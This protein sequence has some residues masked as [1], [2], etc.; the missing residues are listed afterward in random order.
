MLATVQGTLKEDGTLE[1]DEQL[2]LPPG[3]VRITVQ[4]SVSVE[5][6]ETMWT[7]LERIWSAQAVRGHVPPTREEVET[8]I[9]EMRAEWDDRDEFLD[10]I[11]NGDELKPCDE[12][13]LEANP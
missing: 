6:G 1:L 8:Y 7:T 10:R 2:D 13:S 3:P 12:N 4:A 9:D 11:R 5:S